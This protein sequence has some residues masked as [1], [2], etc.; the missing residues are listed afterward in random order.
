M[1]SVFGPSSLALRHDQR[2]DCT[3][4]QAGC[5][6]SM[7]LGAER[8]IQ[9]HL[10]SRTSPVYQRI[11]QLKSSEFGNVA[12]SVTEAASLL[13]PSVFVKHDAAS[14]LPVDSYLL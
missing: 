10:G 8:V 14:D 9:Y 4:G 12:G 5:N 3:Y 6:V 1:G 7:L 13:P 11:C 2:S